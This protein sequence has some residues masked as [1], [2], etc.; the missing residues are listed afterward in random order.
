MTLEENRADKWRLS[1]GGI[2]A[3]KNEKKEYHP[4]KP[5]AL[6]HFLNVHP[7]IKQIEICTNNDRPGRM[8]AEAMKKQYERNYQIIMNLPQREGADYGDLAKERSEMM[9][10]I[11]LPGIFQFLYCS[12]DAGSFELELR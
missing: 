1:L 11:D 3:P 7:E 10:E 5:L 9:L 2:Y 8:A 4:K 6:E 12:A